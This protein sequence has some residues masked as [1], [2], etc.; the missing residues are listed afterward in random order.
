[1]TFEDIISVPPYS[2]K[3]NEKDKMLTERLVELTE[4]HR[5]KCV[6]YRQMLEAIGYD[7]EKIL[8][9]TDIPFLPVRLFKELDSENDDV[10]GDNRTGS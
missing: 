10:L 4:T 9:Y 6:Q 5:E 3:K 1:M 2:L 8:S 7:K